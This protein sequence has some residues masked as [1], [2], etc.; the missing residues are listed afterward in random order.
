MLIC[1]GTSSTLP[2]TVSGDIRRIAIKHPVRRSTIIGMVVSK[3]RVILT[4]GSIA[5][6]LAIASSLVRMN[7]GL[8]VTGGKGVCGDGGVGRGDG[9]DGDGSLC[10]CLDGFG[11]SLLSFLICL[12]VKKLLTSGI[13]RA[14][15]FASFSALRLARSWS[16]M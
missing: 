7:D 2:T 1:L 11:R 3:A 9:S 12:V 4:V 8:G 13:L 15:C 16:R 5:D 6:E 10:F 14:S